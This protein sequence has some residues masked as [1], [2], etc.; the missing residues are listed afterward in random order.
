[1]NNFI[2]NNWE[3]YRRQL[4]PEIIETKSIIRKNDDKPQIYIIDFKAKLQINKTT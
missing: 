1:M 4:G 3:L 2:Y